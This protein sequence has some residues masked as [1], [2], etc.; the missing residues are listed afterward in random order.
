MAEERKHCAFQCPEKIMFKRP[1]TWG[2][3]QLQG[4]LLVVSVVMAVVYK[5]H[6]CSFIIIHYTHLQRLEVAKINAASLCNFAKPDSQIS[7]EPSTLNEDVCE[8]AF[9]L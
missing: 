6:K 8:A 3:Y 5:K 4:N 1:M 9:S 2:V 7:P